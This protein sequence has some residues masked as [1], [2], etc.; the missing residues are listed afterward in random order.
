MLSLSHILPITSTEPNNFPPMNVTNSLTSAT[1]RPRGC[2]CG[3][4]GIRAEDMIPSRRGSIYGTVVYVP[5][6]QAIHH[7][8]PSGRLWWDPT[9]SERTEDAG[10]ANCACSPI[11]PQRG[12]H[13]LG[14]HLHRLLRTAAASSLHSGLIAMYSTRNHQACCGANNSG[15]IGSL[16]CVAFHRGVP[17]AERG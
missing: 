1:G 12:L 3:V 2:E 8:V 5:P 14:P 6:Y 13:L 7:I 17:T 10:G 11:N 16:R 9:R 4:G 15:A